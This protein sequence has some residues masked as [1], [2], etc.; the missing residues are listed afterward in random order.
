MPTL[1]KP[2]L[3]ADVAREALRGLAH[4][5]RSIEDPTEI[6]AV[7]GALSGGLASLEQVLHQLGGFHDAPARTPTGTPAPATGAVRAGRAAAYQVAWELH[8]AAEIV[9]QAAAG[10]D[11][12]HEVEASISYDVCAAPPTQHRPASPGPGL[13]L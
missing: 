4:A 12:A 9:H 1:N 7:L 5:T 8:R 6:Y 10:L 11:R 13:S 3:D 2:S